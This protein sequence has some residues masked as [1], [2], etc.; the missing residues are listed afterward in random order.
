MN[1]FEAAGFTLLFFL[2]A[3]LFVSAQH[4][5]TEKFKVGLLRADGTLVPFA[6]YRHG[7]W[8][9]PWAEIQTVE[10]GEITPKSLGNQPEPWFR[11]NKGDSANWYFWSSPNV[12]FTL[13]AQKLL[14]IENHS[15]KNWAV[16]TNYSRKRAG[17]DKNDAAH[18]YAGFALDANLKTNDTIKVEKNGGE[19]AYIMRYMKPIFVDAENTEINNLLADPNYKEYAGGFPASDEQRAKFD[20]TVKKLSRSREAFDGTHVYYIEL[21][22]EYGKP[23]AVSGGISCN[24]VAFFKGWLLK[25]KKGTLSLVN[26]E[27]TLDDCDGKGKGSVVMLFNALTLNG[28]TFLLTVEH[29]WEDESYVIYELKDYGITRLL[30]TFGG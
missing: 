21:E 5:Q 24:N 19:V 15:Q 29:G 6:E 13:K 10:G 17:S 7:L 9:N 14:Q 16:M 18:S 26:E 22:R 27:F 30:E 20:M 4:P 25:D 3:S 28:R 12:L 23:A 11:Q 1:K 2:C 8:W